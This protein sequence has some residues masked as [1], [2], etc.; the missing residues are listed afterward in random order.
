MPG[1]SGSTPRDIQRCLGRLSGPRRVFLIVMITVEA[2]T[3]VAP[4]QTVKIELPKSVAP[5]PHRLVLVI[6]EAPLEAAPRKPAA[7]L[8]LTKLHLSG[9][10]AGSTFR[11]EDVYGDTER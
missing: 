7:P 3:E 4:D 11:R 1:E 10:P 5:G 6:E 8:R 9:W 2:V